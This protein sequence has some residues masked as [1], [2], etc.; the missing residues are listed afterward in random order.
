MTGYSA[1]DQANPTIAPPASPWAS[2]SSASLIQR[3]P[4]HR[5]AS[6]SP[7]RCKKQA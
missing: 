1:G 5:N 4:A 6:A 3:C 7:P 2:E